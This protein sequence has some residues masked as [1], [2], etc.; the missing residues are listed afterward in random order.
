MRQ[1]IGNLCSSC[2]IRDMLCR[3]NAR[4]LQRLEL[5]GRDADYRVRTRQPDTADCLAPES[6]GLDDL[7]ELAV[8]RGV[9]PFAAN[10]LYISFSNYEMALIEF[11]ADSYSLYPFHI[12]DA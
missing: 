5:C 10:Q 2:D 9:A 8:V 7:A 12:L 3:A 1:S 4:T 11:R 6:L